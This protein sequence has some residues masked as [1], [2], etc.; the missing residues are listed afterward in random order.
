[1]ALQFAFTETI[2]IF[3]FFPHHLIYPLNS[4]CPPGLGW[5]P[6]LPGS[7]ASPDSWCQLCL[8]TSVLVQPTLWLGTKA[9]GALSSQCVGELH[10][11]HT[12]ARKAPGRLPGP[13]DSQD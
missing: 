1:L 10:R 11:H 2:P 5:A 13:R 12:N 6:A 7:P 9:F 4:A 8:T 3:W